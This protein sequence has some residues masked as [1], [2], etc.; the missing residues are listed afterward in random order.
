ME[1]FEADAC[2]CGIWTLLHVDLCFKDG[3]LPLRKLEA[4]MLLHTAELNGSQWSLL[5][6]ERTT[7]FLAVISLY[8]FLL[9][10][11]KGFPLVL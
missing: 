2:H 4:A 6:I 8:H 1:C 9:A 10:D 7:D 11:I 5:D 3:D